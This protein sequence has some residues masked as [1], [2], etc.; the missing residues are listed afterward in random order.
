MVTR[1]RTQLVAALTLLCGTALVARSG[2]QPAATPKP[3]TSASAKAPPIDTGKLGAPTTSAA[4]PTPAPATA[5]TPAPA[6]VPLP[7]PPVAA[8][9]SSAAPPAAS[10]SGPPVTTATAPGQVEPYVAHA[11]LSVAKPHEAID[12]TIELFNPHLAKRVLLIYQHDNVLEEVPLLRNAEGYVARVPAE[13]VNPPGI[14]YAIEIET[15]DGRRVQGF[16]TRTA[17]HS[18]QVPDDVDDVR[19]HHLIKRLDDR[20]SLAIG[21]FDY[22]YYGRSTSDPDVNG[23]TKAVPDYYWRSEIAY[24]YRPLRHV[25]EFGIRLGIVR[26]ESP[27]GTPQDGKGKYGSKVGLNYG[28]PTAIFRASDLFHIEASLLTSVTEIGFSGGVGGALHI[29]DPYGTK[30]VL[31][32]EAIKTFGSRGWVRLDIVRSRVRVS[33]VVEVGDIPNARPGVRLYTELAIQLPAGFLVVMRGGYQ[34]RDFTSGGASGGLSF[35]YAF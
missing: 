4:T 21:S 15:T 30:L 1:R 17:L 27:I 34:A 28:S 26:G 20:R 19:E 33:P 10:S 31:A 8:A 6:T 5:P 12:L 35:G 18:V 29:G 14:A 7:P 24:F 11:P 2:A 25:L 22:V 13:H 9:S 23:I 3:A 16:A 32:A